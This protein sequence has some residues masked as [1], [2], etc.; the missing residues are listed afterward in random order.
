MTSLDWFFWQAAQITMHASSSH[1][2]FNSWKQNTGFIWVIVRCPR[3][4]RK[5][6]TVSRALRLRQ[7]GQEI[8]MTTVRPW[9]LHITSHPPL[10]NPPM[11]LWSALR[12]GMIHKTFTVAAAQDELR[13]VGFSPYCFHLASSLRR[14]TKR[15][16]QQGNREVIK[17]WDLISAFAISQRPAFECQVG[18]PARCKLGRS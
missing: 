9:V 7:L 10:H 13:Q 6:H 4:P 2:V 16:T 18:L 8:K 3:I 14:S 12:R 15:G 17:F 11:T 1:G 5:S